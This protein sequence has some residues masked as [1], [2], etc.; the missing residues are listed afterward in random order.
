MPNMKPA[1]G[2]APA[3]VPNANVFLLIVYSDVRSYKAAYG[4]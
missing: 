3:A 4:R 1:P 2:A